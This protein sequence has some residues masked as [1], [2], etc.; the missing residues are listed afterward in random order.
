MERVLVTGADGFIGTHLLRAPLRFQPVLHVHREES[1]AR[2]L[3]HGF[4]VFAGDLGG[5]ACLENVPPVDAVVH[6]AGRSGGPARELYAAN[7]VTV[8][9]LLDWMAA[10]QVPR[11]VLAST[12][13][14]YAGDARRA[15]VETDPPL[16]ASHYGASKWAAELA[17]NQA[18]ADSRG[19]LAATILRFPN[20]YGPGSRKG[21]V[22]NFLDSGV[23]AGA[24]LLDGEGMQERDFLYVGD[25]V[26]AILAALDAPATG[27]LTLNIATGR[28]TSLA[29]LA[30]LIGRTLRS[31]IALRPSGR[32][33]Q[34]PRCL[35]M[36]ASAARSRLAWSAS[37][38]LDEGIAKT[39][40][41]RLAPAVG[42]AHP[43]S[44]ASA[45]RS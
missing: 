1:R 29:N 20:V 35:W 12:G 39:V 44:A 40:A 6:L 8:A 33:E 17:V 13:A 30:A 9:A 15:S 14:L 43:A 26:A 28:K 21:V 41:W 36:D 3:D 11:L 25:A 19:N 18:V 10:R 37:V 4:E 2:W 23:R 34:P 45:A 38:L 24:V 32:P 31:D 16:P 22:W 5:G 42:E 7:A 27:A